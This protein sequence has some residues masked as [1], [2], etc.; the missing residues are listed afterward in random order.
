M[1]LDSLIFNGC[2]K[3]SFKNMTELNIFLSYFAVCWCFSKFHFYNKLHCKNIFTHK[4]L[5]VNFIISLG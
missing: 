1:F 4:F 3:F 2:L 5:I